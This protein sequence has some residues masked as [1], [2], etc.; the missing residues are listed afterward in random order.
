MKNYDFSMSDA[1]FD[2]DT[3]T[4]NVGTAYMEK[5][6]VPLKTVFGTQMKFLLTHI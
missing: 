6:H 5:I 3:D 2:E 4:T 1:Y